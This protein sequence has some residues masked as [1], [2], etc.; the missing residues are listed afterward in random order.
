[1][2]QSRRTGRTPPVVFD[3]AVWA[4]DLR[5]ASATARRSASAARALY[6]S[7][8]VP[9]AELR[10]CA[11]EG[12]DGT[13]LERCMKVYVPAPAGPH[14]LVFQIGRDANGKLALA[15]LAF[16]LRHPTRDMRQPSVYEVAHRR[17]HQAPE[18]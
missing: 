12:P 18:D 9:F 16:G 15:Y 2:P 10:A 7:G 11:P 3:D 8:G 17:L 6:E 5:R 13:Q 14:G 1:V 4:E